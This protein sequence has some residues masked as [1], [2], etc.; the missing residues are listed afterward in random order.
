TKPNGAPGNDKYENSALFYYLK[1]LSIT[2]CTDGTSKTVMI[3]EIVDGHTQN[4][5]NIWSRSVRVMDK[6]RVTRNPLNT[7]PGEGTVLSSSGLRVNGAFASRHP[8][9]CHFV[10]AD[11]HVQFLRETLSAETY[12]AV[13][14]RDVGDTVPESL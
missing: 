2:K 11:G 7:W 13:M 1:T 4:P 9:G 12:D 6:H 3:G 5:S 10:F 14:T 8:A